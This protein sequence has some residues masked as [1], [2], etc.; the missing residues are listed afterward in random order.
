M[1]RSNVRRSS[2]SW[3]SSGVN[4]C[5]LASQ[6]RRLLP[7]VDFGSGIV[8]VLEACLKSLAVFVFVV[9]VDAGVDGVSAL[10]GNDGGVAGTIQR[11][12]NRRSV[13]DTQLYPNVSPWRKC[14]QG[15]LAPRGC[16]APR[17]GLLS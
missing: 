17:H 15:R 8:D 2:S 6:P 16:C 14:A 1:T 7:C 4:A 13:T 11:T 10:F 12:N 3:V 9:H 5:D